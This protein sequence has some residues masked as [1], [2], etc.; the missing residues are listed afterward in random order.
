MSFSCQGTA[1]PA[2]SVDRTEEGYR[3]FSCFHFSFGIVKYGYSSSSG[4]DCPNPL[5]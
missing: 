4:K 5:L 2:G 3:I 1:I